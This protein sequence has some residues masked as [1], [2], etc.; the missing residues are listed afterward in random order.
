MRFLGKIAFV[1][2]NKEMSYR[3]NGISHVK[4]LIIVR[5]HLRQRDKMYHSISIDRSYDLLLFT[6]IILLFSFQHL[7]I[8]ILS[9]F[10]RCQTQTKLG[11]FKYKC[12]T[13][14]CVGKFVG[15]SPMLPA[16]I[17]MRICKQFLQCMIVWDSYSSP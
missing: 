5:T 15:N 1:C 17:I 9:A 2:M 14:F 12:H 6:V 3:V 8:V 10:M 7:T 16:T 4:I 13:I 11:T